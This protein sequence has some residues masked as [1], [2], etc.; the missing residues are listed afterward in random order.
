MVK[1]EDQLMTETITLIR[2]HEECI[3]MKD[4]DTDWLIY[5]LVAR[6]PSWTTD[7][8]VSASGLDLSVVE[9]SLG[10]LERNLLLERADGRVRVLAVGEALLLC[11]IKN[12]KDLPYCI[13]NGVIRERRK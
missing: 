13:E 3:K 4:E 7:E 6:Q 1:R 5:H 9:K 12:T 8:L 2:A 10:R 11:Q